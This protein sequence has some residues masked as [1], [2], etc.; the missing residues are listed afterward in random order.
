MK[1]SHVAWVKINESNLSQKTNRNPSKW[2]V[3]RYPLFMT[4]MKIFFSLHVELVL[5]SAFYAPCIYSVSYSAFYLK[6]LK[7]R[8]GFHQKETF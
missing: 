6:Q 5:L 3:G 2:W 7:T 8:R 1:L 4:E